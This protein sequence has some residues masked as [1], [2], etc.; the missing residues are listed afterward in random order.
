MLSLLQIEN[1]AVIEQAEISFNGGFNVLTG[2]TGA[3]KSIIIDAISAVLGERTSRDV[4]RTGAFLARVSAVFEEIPKLSWFEENSVEYD[5]SGELL[6]LREIFPDGKNVCKVNG[7][8]VTVSILK[9]LGARLINIH[10]QHDSQQLF[11]EENHLSYLDGFGN[12]EP[13]VLEFSKAFEQLTAISREIEGI[14]MGDSEK[15]RLKETLT[16]QINELEAARL[17]DGEEETLASRKKILSNAE[18]ITAA[19][20]EAY[21]AIAGDENSD[22]AAALLNQAQ[23]S[24][25]L[26]S[27][28]SDD[29]SAAEERLSDLMYQAEDVAELLRDMRSGF[30]YSEG[31]LEG[32]ESRLDVIYRLK[33][34]YGS[35]IS[36]MLEFLEKCKNQL[37][38][39]EFSDQKLEKLNRDLQQQLDITK[40]IASE[41]S[42]KRKTAAKKLESRV[43]SEL[44]Q[45]D[46]DKVRFEI[47]F[48][49]LETL[50]STG[51]DRVRFLMSANV[52]ESLKPISKIASG[53]ELARIMLALKN[54]LAE[55]DEVPTLIFDEVDS[56]V[57]G[58]AAQ[59][60]AEKLASV[61][62]KKQVLCVTHL[63]QIAA[64][65]DTHFSIEKA[66]KNGRTYTSVLPLDF[67][68]RKAELARIIGGVAIT[69]TT[70]KNAEEMLK[71]GGHT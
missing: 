18:K 50:H 14:S 28:L 46:M 24:L 16:Y 33:R 66:E 3:G 32:L 17:K 19:V 2:E 69:K 15:L 53:G 5:E 29:L 39:I 55:N 61:A 60:V 7:R 4:I 52:G 34:K 10:G 56:G 64:L 44:N 65:A 48:E 26:A 68:G 59:K 41:L 31:E 25:S 62:E 8:P 47:E 38:D 23:R 43:L 1:I 37:D 42:E 70:L 63:P 40:A 54:V 45:L 57:S 12:L 22:G 27:S 6:I 20:E 58:R 36:E 21:Y 30:E 67:E 71:Y 51:G 35:T 11:D 49:P 9:Q 13:F